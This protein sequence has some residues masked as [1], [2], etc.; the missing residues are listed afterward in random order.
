MRVEVGRQG[1]RAGVEP[2]AGRPTGARRILLLLA[3]CIVVV[4]LI[5][6]AVPVYVLPGVKAWAEYRGHGVLRDDLRLITQLPSIPPRMFRSVEIPHL[7]IDVKFKNM[8][9]IFL[10]R[11]EALARGFLITDDND[12]VPATLRV[13]DRSVNAKLRLKGDL[14]DH[15]EKDKWSFR[16]QVQGG[17]Q[18]FGLRRFSIQDPSTRG[19]QAEILFLE[20]LRGFGV[21]APRY[22]FTRMTLNGKEMGLMAVEEHFSTELLEASGRRDGP[23]V[24]FD[25]T[26]FWDSFLI[27]PFWWYGNPFLDFRNTRLEAFDSARI[28]KSPAL[29]RQLSTA[30]GLVRGF[31]QRR[32]AAADVFDPELMGAF[33]AVAEF[34]GAWHA[35]DWRNHR[36]YFNPITTRLEP[37]GFDAGVHGRVRVG[38]KL[39]DQPLVSALL[40]DPK[41]RAARD[42]ALRELAERT[43]TG[44]LIRKL[45][46]VEDPQLAI[47]QTEYYFANPFPYDELVERAKLVE[48]TLNGEPP[49]DAVSPASY[50]TILHADITGE[51][52]ASNLE[53]TS[54]V[55]HEVEVQSIQ[56]VSPGNDAPLSFSPEPALALPFVLGPRAF[57]AVLS[58]IRIPFQPQGIPSGYSL[59]V[60]ARIRGQERVSR[61]LARPYYSALAGVPIPASSL[62]EQLARHPFLV[63]GQG[64]DTLRVKP[65][66]WQVDG[67]L[68]VPE[69][70]RLIAG[71]G[72]TLRFGPGGGIVSHGPLEFVGEE[73]SPVVL[74]GLPAEGEAGRWQGVAVLAAGAPSRF[75]HV[76]IRNTSG[77]AQAGWELTGG[78]TFFRSD[79]E[80]ED[81]RFEGNSA[82]DAINV[83]GSRFA[84]RRM[85]IVDTKSDALDSDFSEG[86]MDDVLFEKIGQAGGGD[87]VD[88]SGSTVTLRGG[89]F[90][91]IQDKA[92]SVGEKSTMTASA[93][94]IDG[95]GTGA[96]SKDGSRLELFDSTVSRVRF[97]GLAAYIKK[98]GYGSA[99]IEARNI[100]FSQV[101]SQA[102]AQTGSEVTIDGVP[103]TPREVD[104]DQ[105][106]ETIMR[107]AR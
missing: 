64:D 80:I 33:I 36:Y 52:A 28:Q 85:V 59:E 43:T 67:W 12:F 104:V 48:R 63:P 14:P 89:R 32:L 35:I 75:S 98:P 95:A 78:V 79:V 69:G 70:S 5:T 44:E 49:A 21:L 26:L 71:P 10:K 103:V 29:S 31:E 56:W 9:K 18:V 84:F 51:A 62:K 99:R 27:R 20:T 60:T 45:E 53:L 2:T 57:D 11:N 94:R 83:F 46:A 86:T 106:Y 96:A 1:H 88:L 17:D 90:V 93:V 55:P 41:I 54:A 25:E 30:V 81:S 50:Q 47:L 97:T 76:I 3:S 58:P 40:E 68:V 91:D 38:R 42:A 34:W 19:Y 100:T 102:L 107:P 39:P 61:T 92:L 73:G 15:W 24:R 13:G 23:I 6:L 16:I 7:V 74:E 77:I 22:F 87:A 66:A 105:L 8:Q 37:I 101:D 82:E 72:T 65:G 4:S